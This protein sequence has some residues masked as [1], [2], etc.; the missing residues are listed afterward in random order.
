VKAILERAPTATQQFDEASG[1]ADIARADFG[2]N[3]LSG[4]RRRSLKIN[5]PALDRVCWSHSA[6]TGARIAILQ[7][8]VQECEYP[9]SGCVVTRQRERLGLLLSA[10]AAATP[11]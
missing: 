9:F 2:R 10:T 3:G 1:L 8:T 4:S 6:R 5:L 7:G 11:R